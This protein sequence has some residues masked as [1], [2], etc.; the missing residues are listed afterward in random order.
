MVKLVVLAAVMAAALVLN[1]IPAA[2]AAPSC[3]TVTSELTPC[4]RFITD[5]DN[6]PSVPCCEGVR[7]VENE[8]H[9]IQDS[10]TICDCIKQA[11]TNITFVDAL[12]IPQLPPL[13]G[14]P[15]QLP[16][17]DD[18]FNCSRCFICICSLLVH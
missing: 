9:E 1:M 17:I 3:S 13:C 10:V 16:P 6:T 5:A 7:Y 2:T 15:I 8:I 18:Q 11:I 14:V 4:L 12:R